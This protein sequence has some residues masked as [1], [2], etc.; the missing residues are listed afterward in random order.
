LE[1]KWD[2]FDENLKNI[3]DRIYQILDRLTAEYSSLR[4]KIHEI[5]KMLERMEGQLG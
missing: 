4:V 1:K 5:E 2:Q 3:T